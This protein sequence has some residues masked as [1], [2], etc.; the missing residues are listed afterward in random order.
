MLINAYYIN[1]V[2]KQVKLTEDFSGNINPEAP[3]EV[4]WDN[5]DDTIQKSIEGVNTLDKAKNYLNMLHNK[6]KGFPINAKKK[7]LSI[8]ILALGTIML[9]NIGKTKDELIDELPPDLKTTLVTLDNPIIR[10]IHDKTTTPKKSVKIRNV[11]ESLIEFLKDEEGSARKRGEPILTAYDDGPK[12]TAIGWGHSERNNK[13]ELVSG[14]TTISYKEA[15]ELLKKDIKIAS[16]ALN[17]ILHKWDTRKLDVI[18]TQGM[19]DAM[20][21]LIYNMG[22]GNFRKSNIIKLVKRNQLAQAKEEIK[23][24]AVIYNGHIARR[25]KES[26]MFSIP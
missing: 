18:V 17:R 20:V 6:T 25:A 14:E 1:K 7:V 12:Q 10:K 2:S 21:S 9:S 4:T 11:S 19:Y 3:N 15:E 13:T 8:A 26:D 5:I 23:T 22:I 24:T 16:N